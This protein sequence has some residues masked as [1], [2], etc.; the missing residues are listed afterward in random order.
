MYEC[1]LKMSSVCHVSEIATCPNVISHRFCAWTWHVVCMDDGNQVMSAPMLIL[2]SAELVRA[3]VSTAFG[4][5]KFAIDRLLGL[6][7]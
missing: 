1:D 7:S 6:C 2:T 3:L 5:V 4:R